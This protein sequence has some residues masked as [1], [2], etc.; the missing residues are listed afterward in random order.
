[1]AGDIA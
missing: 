1:M